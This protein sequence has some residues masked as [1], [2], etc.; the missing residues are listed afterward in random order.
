MAKRKQ[1]SADFR[2][3]VAPAA[4]RGDGTVAELASRYEIHPNMIA[5]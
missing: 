2:V 4:I 5:K 1:Y 3:K